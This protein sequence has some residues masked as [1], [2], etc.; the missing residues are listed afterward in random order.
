MD[1]VKHTNHALHFEM[2][3]SKV[4]FYVTETLRQA[5]VVNYDV[6]F[7]Q[8]TVTYFGCKSEKYLEE[9]LTRL[10]TRNMISYGL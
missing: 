9:Y 5:E 6:D 7:L 2:L 4:Y 10:E 8:R 1:C 3:P